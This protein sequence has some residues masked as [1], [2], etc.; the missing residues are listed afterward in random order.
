MKTTETGA[1]ELLR[2]SAELSKLAESLPDPVVR[3]LGQA[4]NE[5]SHLS[6]LWQEYDWNYLED[7]DFKK[8]AGRAKTGKELNFL[9]LS[10]I[11]R[12][13]EAFQIVS[14]WRMADLASGSIRSLNHYE[15]ISAC[16]LSRAMIEL[17][18]RYGDVANFLFRYFESVAWEKYETDA[19]R[20]E[21][22]KD[23][24][25]DKN[26][27]TLEAYVERLMD[28]TRLKARL[29]LS[30][31]MQATN[32]MTII[33]RLDKKL[34]KQNAGYSVM[35]HYENLC[36][37]AHPNVLGYHRFMHAVAKHPSSGWHIRKMHQ[38]ASSSSAAY[39]VHECL[40]AVAFSLGSMGGCF[41]V[42]QDLK[43]LLRSK[44]G[45]PLPRH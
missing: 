35:S 11:M 28:A 44:V 8:Q 19:I 26:G 23:S 40:W 10:H 31:Q 5:F 29:Q 22:P 41:S 16:T 39:L 33:Q 34:S 20:F 18:A 38:H 24:S 13:I 9:F 6:S 4:I 17:V 45:K 37:V 25:D 2:L 1:A 27:E 12:V 21:M 7:D 32:I 30:E 42:F 15:L 43:N 3:S 36:E 14:I